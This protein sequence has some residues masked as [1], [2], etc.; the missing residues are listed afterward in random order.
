MTVIP[1]GLDPHAVQYGED[2]YPPEPRHAFGGPSVYEDEHIYEEPTIGP[3]WLPQTHYAVSP[4]ESQTRAMIPTQYA[5]GYTGGAPMS[6][7][8]PT[9]ASHPGLSRTAR[10]RPTSAR[11]DPMPRYAP[12]PGKTSPSK[13]SF[14]APAVPVRRCSKANKLKRVK[15]KWYINK[16]SKNWEGWFSTGFPSCPISMFQKEDSQFHLHHENLLSKY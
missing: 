16:S 1:L 14:A 15:L 5:R 12:S 11:T 3:S 2:H 8:R 9:S 10:T 4:R 13:R 7:G 6:R